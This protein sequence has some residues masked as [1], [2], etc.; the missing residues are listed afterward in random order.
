MVSFWFVSSEYMESDLSV[1]HRPLLDLR[2]RGFL[3][4]YHC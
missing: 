3:S 4:W 1:E 2:R